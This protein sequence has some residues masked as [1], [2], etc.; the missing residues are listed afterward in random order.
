MVWCVGVGPVMEPWRMGGGT[1][2][3]VSSVAMSS[4]STPFTDAFNLE[5]T[6]EF[7]P[8][9]CWGPLKSSAINSFANY[10]TVS[11]I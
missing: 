10:A 8:L 6:R 5:D 4:L 7:S 9:S 3:T 2:S 11:I 1:L